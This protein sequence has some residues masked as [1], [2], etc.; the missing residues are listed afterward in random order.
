MAPADRLDSWK[1]I[2]GYLRRG[3]RT[4]QRWELEAGLP[5]RRI[6]GAT[7]A[8]YAFRSELDAWWRRRSVA[9]DGTG[10]GGATA[11]GPPP[12]LPAA[13]WPRPRVRPFLPHELKVDPDSASGHADLAV[14]FFTLAMVGLMRPEEAMPAAR[15]AAQRALQIAPRQAEAHAMLAVVAAQFDRDWI[16]AE[17]RWRLAWE[18]EP[19]PPMVR[20]HYSPFFLE[21][22]GRFAE[23][24]RNLEP[25]LAAEPLY[26]LGR[27]ERAT[28][29]IGVGRLADGIAEFEHIRAIDPHFAPAAGLLGRE[30]VFAGRLDESFALAEIAHGAAPHHPNAVGFL[31][32]LLERRGARERSAA[33]LAAH[34][35]EREWSLPR[36]RAEAHVACE[37]YDLA[38]D[39]LA[40]AVAQHDPGVGILLGGTARK[41]LCAT[42]R[43]PSVRA[44]LNLPADVV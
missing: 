33:L 12:D 9:V 29:L 18:V 25:A 11:V 23:S 34:A 22:L 41:A 3:V 30:R 38:M 39:A 4:A 27:V 44:A 14:Y 36:A 2:A 8:V 20:F 10:A 13:A 7:G 5:V 35:R 28:G 31:A 15:G 21:P 24:L 43:W 40:D 32:G 37:R 17:R 16:E 19:V 26:L 1:E 42:R 6:G